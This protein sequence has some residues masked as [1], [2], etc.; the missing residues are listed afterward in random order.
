[1]AGWVGPVSTTPLPGCVCLS[2]HHLGPA[3][4]PAWPLSTSA[5]GQWPL[6]WGE[7]PSYQS[8]YQGECYHGDR[9]KVGP[10][11]LG[12]HPLAGSVRRRVG[13]VILVTLVLGLPWQR[14]S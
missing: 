13:V 8:Y 12:K 5:L 1:M 14:V 6:P 4:F 7:S 9:T 11:A 3:R 2:P 10:T